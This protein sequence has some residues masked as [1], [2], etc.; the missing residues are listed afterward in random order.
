MITPDEVAQFRTLIERRLGLVFD[1][2]KL[3][4]LE[5]LLRRRCADRRLT[6]A[7]FLASLELDAGP[8]L[9]ALAAELTVG[10]TY[11]F[12]NR[13]QFTALAQAV[14][15]DRLRAGK[16]L[17]M[18]SA[19]CASG[20]EPYTIA[21]VAREA[22]LDLGAESIRAIDVNPEALQR[23]AR[24]RYTSWALRETPAAVQQAWFRVD[25]REFV[26]H[27]SIKTAVQFKR[28]N[29]V[30]EEGDVW[31][32]NTYDVVFCRN[33]IMYFAPETMKRV[34]ARIA[35]AL[36]PGGY[37]FLGHAET[38]RGLSADFHLCHTHG[39]FYYQRRD[40]E[41][42][43]VVD[44]P[45]PT[46][47]SLVAVIADADSWVD[48]IHRASERIRSLT[49]EVPPVTPAHVPPRWDLGS[50]LELLRDERFGD[51]LSLVEG[52]PAESMR[53]PDVLLLHAVLLA[54][55]GRFPAAEAVCRALLAIDEHHAGAHYIL[56]LC[57]EASGDST[58]AIEHDQIALFLD[59]QFAMARLHLGLLARRAGD[60]DSARRE[61]A[62]AAELLQREDPS[63]LLLFGGGFH[64]DALISLCRAEVPQ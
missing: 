48:A 36:R 43:A 2:S 33:V 59:P 62:Q 30:D 60:R 1:D 42:S 45:S 18:L 12:R 46:D 50:A 20:E 15:P 9:D 4:R 22:G 16:P 41:A 44:V 31:M 34:I 26:L 7:G 37:L 28:A 54:H 49:A 8:E 14:F 47:T 55:A 51:A 17:R 53:D 35:R 19:G 5:E 13:D 10:E 25:G 64:R 6:P 58:A 61:L 57:R 56:A 24:G 11:F 38:L 29:L 63:R 3:A 27:E 23:A 21:I 32:P 39:T 40:G 52:M